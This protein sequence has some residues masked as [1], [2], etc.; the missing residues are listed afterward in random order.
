MFQVLKKRNYQGWI[1]MEVF[2]FTPGPEKILA[3]AGAYLR[4][5]IAGLA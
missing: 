2:D 5:Q 3:E 4:D 1:S